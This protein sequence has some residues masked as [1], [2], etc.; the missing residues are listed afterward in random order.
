LPLLSSCRD[1]PADPSPLPELAGWQAGPA[2]RDPSFVRRTYRRGAA[3]IT[4]TH[5]RMEMRPGQYEE[6]LAMSRG[7]DFPQAA[8]PL[9]GDRGNGFY[10]CLPA[11]PAK[12]D[13]LVQLRSGV[14]L[15]IRGDG[16]ATREDLDALVRALPWSRM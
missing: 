5:A 10:Q 7:G 3:R 9:P 1:A 6:W 12:C 14:H 13:L 8:L 11:T 2:T 4:V 16:T 15:E